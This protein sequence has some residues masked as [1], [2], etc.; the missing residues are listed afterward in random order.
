MDQSTLLPEQKLEKACNDAATL[1]QCGWAR[2]IETDGFKASLCCKETFQFKCCVDPD[3]S[4]KLIKKN[5]VTFC[6]GTHPGTSREGRMKTANLTYFCDDKPLHQKKPDRNPSKHLPI[7][8]AEP[9]QSTTNSEICAVPP[10]QPIVIAASS[11]H[12]RRSFAVAS[13]PFCSPDSA[14][15]P[16]ILHRPKCHRISRT[17]SSA[18]RLQRDR[19]LHWNTRRPK[20]QLGNNSREDLASDHD[21]ICGIFLG[22]SELFRLRQFGVTYNAILCALKALT[23]L[24]SFAT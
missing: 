8:H 1:C 15:K 21:N 4:F 13:L 10:S 17:H 12:S 19:S 11:L 14:G 2:C 3:Q 20:P 5:T 18:F 23:R 7:P 9:P 22:S 16:S 6:Y 24:S